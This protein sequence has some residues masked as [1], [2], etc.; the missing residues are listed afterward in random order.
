MASDDV[1]G[2]VTHHSRIISTTLP[3]HPARLYHGGKRDLTPNRWVHFSVCVCMY[4]QNR[5]SCLLTLDRGPGIDAATV[6]ASSLGRSGPFPL[7]L[8][9][10][11]P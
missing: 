3:Y 1:V 10:H 9:P 5:Y 8:P 4:K 6:W 11:I 7:N 2:D